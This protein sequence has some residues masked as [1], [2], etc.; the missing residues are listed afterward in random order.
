MEFCPKVSIIIPV[1]N[2]SNYLREAIDS[3]LAQTYKNIEIIV[4]NDGSS[5]EGRTEAIAKSYGDKIRYIYK[6]NG[7]VSTALNVG[8]LAAEGEY[9]SWLSHDDVYMPNK[10]EVQINYLRN[11]K[12]PIILYSDYYFINSESG[13]SGRCRVSNAPPEKFLYMLITSY[14][15]NGCT[16][17]I[18]KACFDIVGLFNEKLK[19]T[20][21][22]EM[23]FRLARKYKFK[24]IRDT[25]IKSRLH[26]E[27]GTHKMSDI[28]M[29]EA[30]NLYIWCLNNFSLDDIFGSSKI[31][32]AGCYIKLAL[33]FKA[34]GHKL[35]SQYA[36]EL[37][38]QNLD[39]SKTFTYYYALFLILYCRIC[40]T[41]FI[42][43]YWKI[44]LKSSIVE[45]SKR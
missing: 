45:L 15:I 32:R 43:D 9:I 19:T 18:P 23:W 28:Q 34:R 24:H 25:L 20:Q 29:T 8:I 40:P 14:P 13:I 1:Y 38:L 30:S 22:Y 39:K 21:D 11:E 44:I 6:K 5:D 42:Y 31:L 7:G 4:I 37:A 17:L 2:G 26:P 33:S 41:I 10:L 35:A 16:T 12:N 27:Q 36:L 3:A